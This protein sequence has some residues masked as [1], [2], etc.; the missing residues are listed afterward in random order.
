LPIALSNQDAEYFWLGMDVDFAVLNEMLDKT[1]NTADTAEN[2]VDLLEGKGGLATEADVKVIEEY[3]ALV[4]R[5]SVYL[6]ML[7]N[8]IRQEI[9]YVAN[10]SYK[11]I[12]E[13]CKFDLPKAYKPFKKINGLT[14]GIPDY[15][16]DAQ[17]MVHQYNNVQ[18]TMRT[19]FQMLSN[20]AVEQGV[21][22]DPI[23][24]FTIREAKHAEHLKKQNTDL[25]LRARLAILSRF[26]N[27]C[28]VCHDDTVRVVATWF[29]AQGF[30]KRRQDLNTFFFNR[31]GQIFHSFYSRSRHEGYEI[32]YDK[33]KCIDLI[34]ELQTLVDTIKTRSFVN[35]NNLKDFNKVE[36]AWMS[37]M[38]SG[39]HHAIPSQMARPQIAEDF[40][41]DGLKLLLKNEVVSPEVTQ[42]L[43]NL[44]HSVLNG[45]AT[46]IFREEFTIKMR[47]LMVGN[48]EFIY[49]AKDKNW[50]PPTH[51]L[52]T[53]SPIHEGLS[54]AGFDS[55]SSMPAQEVIEK[56]SKHYAKDWTRS[57]K[58][59]VDTMSQVPHDWFFDVGVNGIGNE[60]AGIGVSK[61]GLS[62][63]SKNR[64]G[65]R[66][67]GA[68]SYKNE[69]IK[70]LK[71]EQEIG[72]ITLLV[73]RVFKQDVKMQENGDFSMT[74]TE[75]PS[76]WWI[77]TP[78]IQ[79]LS[80]KETEKPAWMDRI[81]AIDL[82]ERGIGYA[83][84]DL[85]TGKVLEDEQKRPISGTKTILSLRQLIRTVDKYKNN[86]QKRQKFTQKFDTR[87]MGYRKNVVGDVCH[88]INDLCARFTA[89]PVLES[90][91]GNLESGAKQLEL[92]YGSVTERYLFSDI[93]ANKSLRK[94]Y[95]MG[96]DRWLH[97]DYKR[98]VMIEGKEVVKPLSLFPGAGVNPSGTSQECS[99]CKRN[100]IKTI[101]D[102][103]QKCF[104]V[105]E[106]GIVQLSNGRI[107]LKQRETMSKEQALRA[108]R[109]AR[110]QKQRPQL[111]AAMQAA[112]LNTDDLIKIVRTNL[113]RPQ[114]DTRSRDTTQSK[115][116]CLYVDCRK[117]IHA[118]EN[119]S[120]NIGYRFVSSLQVV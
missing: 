10:S 64:R 62:K 74:I 84:Y 29:E 93:D 104:T 56:L 92:V 67:I 53:Q 50:T 34:G 38:L 40:I 72:D 98:K 57:N 86:A 114:V 8:R 45:M 95:W 119:A 107:I 24:Q 4:D 105:N 31:R 80:F 55:E 39:M 90:T 112:T 73:E 102:D 106:H 23:G 120:V 118:D 16:A 46:Q 91:V 109:E 9:E 52:K 32:D 7:H 21:K 13:N 97:P 60:I 111:T 20:W 85:K 115:F 33:I 18:F 70:V 5:C 103:D 42:K 75:A 37:I 12:A 65:L 22:F 44:Y 79:P 15:I 51:L 69:V 77:V 6:N 99:C 27:A 96:S 113:R 19:H 47:F 26:S 89:F 71:G 66:M 78:V 58:V 25:D 88:V 2:S 59:L 48:N 68:S 49:H 81:V 100:V 3:S 76:E 30:F 43:F 82:G 116:H 61:D 17:A 87:L 108:A 94:A 83:V 28:R 14:G 63:V 41:P 11:A 110:H 54:I 35:V 1:Q 117:I 101:R 36:R